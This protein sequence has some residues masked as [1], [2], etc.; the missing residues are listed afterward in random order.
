M[1]ENSH[2]V[3]TMIYNVVIYRKM[4]NRRIKNKLEEKIRYSITEHETLHLFYSGYSVVENRSVK[5][6]GLKFDYYKGFI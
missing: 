6:V 1:L 4:E 2:T 3:A 5:S